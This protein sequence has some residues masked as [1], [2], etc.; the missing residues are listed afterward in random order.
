MKVKNKLLSITS[1]K[2]K[3]KSLTTLFLSNQ[4]LHKKS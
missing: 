2:K 4:F 3:I 1:L